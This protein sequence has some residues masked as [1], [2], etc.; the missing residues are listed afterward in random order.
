MIG[1]NQRANV[2]TPNGSDGDYTVLDR[3]NLACRLA[4]VGVSADA[5]PERDEASGKR[6]LLFD[7]AYTMPAR[8]QVEV[9]GSRWNV[10]EGTDAYPTGA[11]GSVVYGRC[12]VI[13]V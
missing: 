3:S 5:A 12:S 9:A 13:K 1:L 7:P 2:Y 8:V 11:A 6:L 4:L 10:E